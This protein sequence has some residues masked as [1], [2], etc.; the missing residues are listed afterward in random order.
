MVAKSSGVR[1]AKD[2]VALEMAE[3][4]SLLER[5]KRIFD[6]IA[7][8]AYAIF[9]SE[10]RVIGRDIEH[11]L[12]AERELLHPVPLS[13]VETDQSIEV[14]AEVPGFGE[15]ELKINIQPRLVTITG[16]REVEETQEKGHTIHCDEC[17]SEIF[18]MIDLPVEVNPAKMTAKLKNGVLIL[19]ISK[20]E[21]VKM[22]RQ[23]KAA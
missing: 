12:R 22:I 1:K 11:W 13:I 6:Q 16:K 10:W 19:S 4:E 18:R 20:A 14:K 17:T 2:A 23:A 5:K 7:R 15:D 8:R 9:E 21:K 3:F